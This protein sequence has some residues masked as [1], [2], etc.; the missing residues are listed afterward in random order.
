MRSEVCIMKRIKH[1]LTLIFASVMVIAAGMQVKAEPYKYK[2]TLLPGLYG[3]VSGS[4]FDV[5]YNEK[6]TLAVNQDA[7]GN[8]VASASYGGDTYTVTVNSDVKNKYYCKGF[9]ISGIEPVVVGNLTITEDTILVAS[10]GMTSKAVKYTVQFLDED[11]NVLAP[12]K[13]FY[14]N[15]GDKPVVSCEYIQDW[16]PDALQKTGTLL[17]PNDPNYQEGVSNVFPF[18]YH[19]AEAIPGGGGGGTTGD[20]GY[21]FVDDGTE[22]VYLPGGGGG[23]GGGNAGG[24][25]GGGNAGGN[26]APAADNANAQDAAAAA[27]AGNDGPAEIIDLDEQE[28]P[29]V[30]PDTPE[31]EVS[32]SVNPKP[33]LNFMWILAMI[34]SGF[35]IIALIAILILLLKRRKK[36]Q[37]QA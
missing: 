17:D 29:L 9:H 31:P 19:P 8:I 5:P 23:G 10:Y 32:P 28:V 37:P 36:E 18:V 7:E 6:V 22:V 2:V 34:L 14:G 27:D 33:G 4:S 15:I 25:A 11:G 12:E 13:T 1:I 20:D 30:N 35:G 3:T 21:T 26:A 16:V 24:N